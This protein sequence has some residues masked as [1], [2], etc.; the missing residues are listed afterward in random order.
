VGPVEA[1]TLVQEAFDALRL[2]VRV[3]GDWVPK[4]DHILAG[5]VNQIGN[6]GHP[7]LRSLR[8][9]RK[10]ARQPSIV[11]SGSA[12]LKLIPPDTSA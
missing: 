5:Y 9:D 11:L 3:G 4:I 10:V 12:N 7:A 2:F 1:D 6:Y 8:N